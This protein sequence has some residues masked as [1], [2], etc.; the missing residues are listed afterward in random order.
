MA[1][2]GGSDSGGRLRGWFV[3]PTQGGRR[4]PQVKAMFVAAPQ[5]GRILC[6]R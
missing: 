4:S 5:G 1:T 6:S 3:A 2:Q